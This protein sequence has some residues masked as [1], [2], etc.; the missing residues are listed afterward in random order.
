MNWRIERF[1]KDCNN[2]LINVTSVILDQDIHNILDAMIDNY[3]KSKKYIQCSNP[4]CFEEFLFS[5]VSNPDILCEEINKAAEYLNDIDSIQ[6]SE[7][8]FG[9]SILIDLENPIYDTSYRK[10]LIYHFLY[11]N[12]KW[13]ADSLRLTRELNWF[14]K[15]DFVD[16]SQC[17]ETVFN[18]GIVEFYKD[19]GWGISDTNGIVICK[20][21]YIDRPST[22]SL[23]SREIPKLVIVQERNSELYG[24]LSLETYKEVLPLEFNKIDILQI[25]G[26]ECPKS[27][28]HLIKVNKGGHYSYNINNKHVFSGGIWGCYS[29]SGEIVL[30]CKYESIQNVSKYIECCLD[31]DYIYYEK[32][33][34]TYEVINVGKRELFD[35]NGKS[36]IKG[37]DLLK[38]YRN[39]LI[40][41]FG[42]YWQPYEVSDHIWDGCTGDI[43]EYKM[44]HYQLCYKQS[45]SLITDEDLFPI[46]K[47][48]NSKNIPEVVNIQNCNDLQRYKKTNILLKGEVDLSNL[49][50]NIIY[51]KISNG[52]EYVIPEF[53]TRNEPSTVFINGRWVDDEYDK[54]GVW[55]DHYYID[56]KVSII[57][58]DSNMIIKWI[59]YV[60][61]ISSYINNKKYC[62]IGSKL[63]YLKEDNFEYVDFTAITIS[64]S[65]KTYI[66]KIPINDNEGTHA[67]VKKVKFFEYT[68]NVSE[69]IEKEI[70]LFNPMK[71]MW[72]PQRFRDYSNYSYSEFEFKIM[73]SGTEP[74]QIDYKN[75]DSLNK[76]IYPEEP[77]F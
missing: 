8:E 7:N 75:L 48:R 20:N 52:D 53:I 29:L 30:Q 72:F 77:P 35:I 4:N 71:Y 60:N 13:E 37:Y 1:E 43:V 39:Y 56:D 17:K 64:G 11:K 61:E 73:V 19:G 58:L 68:D 27:K 51:T 42:V 25:T 38:T 50:N 46:L 12:L 2:P 6:G 74:T 14:E 22:C 33:V 70:H 59:K 31:K 44:E 16:F 36:L 69:C 32:T 3:D 76:E 15:G 63:A 47:K 34:N 57:K 26:N 45:V 18:N 54:N 49:H 23:I 9:L 65:T 21:H 24:V 28:I 62:R 66:A 5:N 10:G 40:F 67:K 55:I 41:Y